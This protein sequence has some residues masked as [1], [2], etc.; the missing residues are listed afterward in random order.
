LRR[1]DVIVPIYK[2]AELV[3]ICVRSLLDH[4]GEIVA[5]KPRVILI[6]DSPGDA[7]VA[8][9]LARYEG[10]LPELMVLRNVVNLGFVQTVNLGLE[11][12]LRDGHDVLLVNS[13]T[14]TFPGTL[15]NLL[16]AAKSDPQI[17]FACPRSNNASI[18][19]LPHFFGGSPPT[20]EIAHQ[21]WLE[22][23]RTFPAYHFSPT[24]VG[25]YLFISHA[26]LAAHGGLHE[27]FGLGYEEENDLVMR[28]GKVG[29]R[30]V[31][32]NQAFAFHAGSASFNLLDM[33]LHSHKHQNLQ[34][35]AGIH[36]EFLCLVR[37]YEGSPHFRAERLM[38]GLLKDA[39]G[40]IK[41]AFDLTGLGLH[42]NGT[43]EH[44]AAAVRSMALRHSNRI[45]V[46]G[47]CSEESFEFH[48][49]DK[50]PGLFRE[51]PGAPGLHAVAL[52]LG[53]PFDMHHVNVLE[54]AA[55]VNLFAMLDT[56]AEDCGPLAADGGF[57]E[58]W[59]HVAEHANGLF[60]NSRFSE[61]TFCNRHPAARAL[62]RWA[63]LLPTRLSSYPKNARASEAKH[64][65][66]LG[67]HFP[68][69]GADAAARTIA[70][71]F[72]SVN[73]VALSSETFRDNNL[74]SYRSGLLGN[75]QVEE[76]FADASV[77]VLPSYV[78]G[79]GFGLMHALAAGRPVVARRIP[80][81]DEILATLDDVQGVFLFEHD[82]DLIQVLREAMKV[83]HSSA[84][85]ERALSW[86]DWTTE[87]ADFCIA[88]TQRDDLFDRLAR[89]ISAADRLRRALRGDALFQQTL[90]SPSNPAVPT[91]TA[92]DAAKPLDLQTLMQLDGTDFVAHAYATLLCRP[93]DSS[94][95]GFYVGELQKGVVKTHVLKALAASAEGRARDVK[96]DGLEKLF[97]QQQAKVPLWKRV[98]GAQQ[99]R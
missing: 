92:S 38:T 4:L 34:K 3:E 13:D 43:N 96:L 97:T 26:V 8:E 37:R 72:P 40:R 50:V 77:V 91:A 84:R 69:K 15:A 78:E 2:N 87:L 63:R 60:F 9:L 86:D 82:S 89:R 22:I 6:N 27:D 98:F 36:P 51:D 55:P 21:R 7:P 25:F 33:D 41:L 80:A 70:R 52:R 61:Q 12:S 44:A 64:V 62:P 1:L 90:P 47:I 23:S 16:R 30:A 31:M 35:L 83:T 66:V 18:C 65:F 59:D 68:H 73:V 79:F 11:L 71:A 20:P 99:T 49:L 56:I 81:T 14:Q 75:A 67:N 29:V 24:A 93:A 95:L 28:A 48:G 57:L 54:G 42:H 19:S 58:L 85:D 10:S 17:G 76:L 39:K 74:T 32:A 45:R 94:G 53:Q 88:L 5:L 46:A